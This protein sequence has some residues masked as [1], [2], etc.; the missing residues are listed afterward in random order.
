M[1]FMK[2]L[3]ASV[4]VGSASVDCIIDNPNC[5]P[6]G[7]LAGRVEIEAGEIEQKINFLAVHLQAEVEIETDDGEY[8]ANQVFHTEKLTEGF[9]LAPGAKQALPFQM[10]V[11][12]EAPLTNIQGQHLR[13]MKVG[14]KTELDI[15][16]GR[17]ST[18]LDLIEV[19]PLPAH[20]RIL[21]AVVGLGFPFKASDCERGKVPGS[22][23]P[24]YQEIEFG[25]APQFAGRINELE[26]T[27]I[28]SPQ[29]VD[30]LLEI[31]NKG[32]FFTEGGDTST[33]FSIPHQGFE[34]TNWEEVISQH[35][36]AAGSRRGLF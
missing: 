6:G 7:M 12:W 32:G 14:V 23:M 24:F 27:F 28:T 13:G 29:G 4:G 9:T 25:A 31:D 16:G 36:Q 3:K 22:T 34:G 10:M 2:K 15:A 30:V 26:V 5:Y 33:R 18:D 11:P 21:A 1:G 19:H 20:E 35:I 17:D 8:K